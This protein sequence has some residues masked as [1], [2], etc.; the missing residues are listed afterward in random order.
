MMKTE[1]INY[2]GMK[3]SMGAVFSV[4]YGKDRVIMDFGSAFDPEKSGYA[5]KDD[6][7]IRDKLDLGLLPGIEGLYP[8]EYLKGY[9]LGSY[10][11]CDYNSAVF[12]SHLHLDH[13][14]NIGAIDR[15]VRVYMSDNAR[16]LEYALEEMK[17]G[18]DTIGREYSTFRNMEYVTVGR[19][20]VL[21][22]MN[23]P[24]SYNMYGFL[25]ETPDMK[26]GYTADLS[27]CYECPEMV[28][29]EMEIFR[30][31]HLDVLYCDNCNFDD[32]SLQRFFGS[33][34]VDSI[35]GSSQIPEG[36]VSFRQHYEYIETLFRGNKGL[37][38]FNHYER[39]MLDVEK[40]YQWAEKENREVVFEPEA[41]WLVYRFFNRK[42]N[43]YLNGYENNDQWFRE[44]LGNAVIVT[45]EDII[46]EPGRY[47]LHNSYG[48]ID[49]LFRLKTPDAVY[50]HAEGNPFN[51]RDKEVMKR[52]VREAGFRFETYDTDNYYQHGYPNMV[53][54]FVETIAPKT[55]IGYHGRYPE[56]ITAA[57]VRTLV[58]DYYKKYYLKNG[59]LTE[60]VEELSY[61]S[62]D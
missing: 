14:S 41:A 52:K 53:K 18:V 43:V 40:Y 7:W 59:K 1:I 37:V 30:G 61:E 39:E 33:A 45:R 2:A 36:M 11:D 38:V 58:P 50:V 9:K 29:R 48:N 4:T 24:Y 23:S 51:S 20:R 55:V 32:K 62:N 31:A 17:Q 47:Y 49:E 21:P 44:L 22:I 56:R 8:A 3:E 16:K 13:M 35:I 25:I 42:V 15:N 27:L 57:N 6:N 34:D 28:H 5:K 19:I 10:Q 60:A 54:Y 26:I 46:R 12:V